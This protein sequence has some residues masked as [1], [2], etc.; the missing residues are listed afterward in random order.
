MKKMLLAGILLLISVAGRAQ[1]QTDNFHYKEMRKCNMNA[2][3]FGGIALGIGGLTTL[4]YYQVKQDQNF[5]VKSGSVLG[6]ICL[7]GV[8][9]NLVMAH[10]HRK[11][12]R[13][14][15][16]ALLMPAESGVGLMVKF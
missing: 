11:A 13:V 1:D 12:L 10:D 16:S 9:L 14:G 2:I 15:K 7:Y 5:I 3:A 6:G 4:G 8:I